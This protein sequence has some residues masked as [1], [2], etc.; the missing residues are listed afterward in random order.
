M[1]DSY[2]KH[3][4]SLATRDLLVVAVTD[5]FFG[6]DYVQDFSLPDHW[7]IAAK[8]RFT[9]DISLMD[10]A[11][12]LWFHGPSTRKLPKKKEGQKW[13]VMSMES[14]QNFPF[15]KNKEIMAMF[16]IAMTYRLDADVPSVYPNWQ[17]YGSFQGRPVSS[18]DKPR[19]LSPL[20]YI[21]SNPVARRD[22]YVGE[23]MNHVSID[24]LGRC[25]N[26]TTNA[27][28]YTGPN[29]WQ[30][31]GFDDVARMLRQYKFY[32]AFEN[33]ISEDYVTERVLMAL[34]NGCVPIYQG[35]PNIEEFLPSDKCIIKTDDFSSPME[36]AEYIK[37]LDRDD[38][39]YDEYLNWRREPLKANFK[40]LVNLGS[41]DPRH[42]MLI[43]LLHGCDRN[44]TCG[45][46]LRC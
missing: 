46:R 34:A 14:E 41:I 11:D 5:H 7:G 24:S 35:A 30:N 37:F 33:S 2:L 21:A 18:A 26:N 12:A 44:C 38:A 31:G 36:L 20:V 15:M 22:D 17:S 29:V 10:Q 13:I 39:T 32:I 25:L 3:L 23:L 43:K 9:D 28:F 42:R 45:G 19:S 16:D 40:E 1:D 8:C 27:D 4:P 6:D